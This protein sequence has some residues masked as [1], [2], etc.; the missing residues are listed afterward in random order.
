MEVSMS[1]KVHTLLIGIDTYQAPVPQLQGCKNDIAAIKSFLEHRVSKNALNLRV[2]EDANATYEN[3]VKGFREHLAQA[4][5]G[6]TAL[7]YYSGHG[8]QEMTAPELWHLEPDR[9][10]ETLVCYDSRQPGKN[11]LADKELSSLIAM[12]AANGAHVVVIL[13][14]CHSGSGTRA[15][16]DDGLTVRRAPL[17]PRGPRSLE[18]FIPE[19]RALKTVTIKP[20]VKA[21]DQPVSWLELPQ[22][23]HILLA[24]CRSSQTAKEVKDTSGQRGAFSVALLAAL[25]SSDGGEDLTYRDLLKRAQANVRNV[26]DDQL[27]QLETRN[28]ADI[29]QP[30]LGGAIMDRG[31]YFTLS[32]NQD[33]WFIDGGA[34]HGLKMPARNEAVML[35]VF[36]LSGSAQIWNDLT[37]SLGTATVTDVKPDRSQVKLELK[38]GSLDQ[39]KTYAAVVTSW[40]MP[41]L[42]VRLEGD[43]DGVKFARKELEHAGPE[44][45]ESLYV[46]LVGSTEPTDYRLLAKSGWY[47]ITKPEGE[48]PIVLELEGYSAENAQKV[49]KQLEH[50]ARWRST[51]QLEN[52]SSKI[53]AKDLSLELFLVKEDDTLEPISTDGGVRLEYQQHSDGKWKQPRI[54]AKLTLA[55]NAPRLYCAFLDLTESFGVSAELNPAGGELLNPGDSLEAREG[56]PIF[57]S[58]P[59][60]LWQQGITEYKDVLKVIVS[61]EEFDARLLEQPD[62]EKPVSRSFEFAPKPRS[63]LERLMKRSNTRSL[64]AESEDDEQ[65]G[66]WRTLEVEFTT[67]RPLAAADVPEEANQDVSLGSGVTLHGHSALKAKVRLGSSKQ[68]TRGIEEHLIPPILRE[69]SDETEPFAFNT[70]RGRDPGLSALELHDVKNRD[71]VTPENPLR[72]TI[73]SPLKQDERVLAYAYDGQ[74]YIPMG[75]GHP[76]DGST[77]IVLGHLPD[78]DLPNTITSRSLG[79]EIKVLFQKLTSK[80]FGLEFKG[81]HLRCADVTPI[82]EVTYSSEEA[83]KSRVEAAKNIVLYVHGIIGD[84]LGMAS[85]INSVNASLAKP[86]DLVLTFDYESVNTP[87]QETAQALKAALEQVG[88]QA[89][90]GKTLH[91]IAHSMGGLVSR[92]MIEV[93]GGK[94]IVGKL[95]ML[96]T[97]NAGSPWPNVQAWATTALTLALNGLTTV[98]WPVKVLSWLVGGIEK[99]DE[100]LDQ[101]TPNSKFLQSLEKNPNPGVPYVLI[102]GNTSLPPAVTERLNG[103]PSVLES[104]LGHINPLYLATAPLFG[105]PNDIAASVSSIRHVPFLGDAQ[106]LQAACNHLNY[107]NT[108]DG[109]GALNKALALPQPALPKPTLPKPTLPKPTLP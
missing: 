69:A 99:I 24:A 54:K 34:V 96:G 109:L 11:D 44:G 33:T 52:P 63:V 48:K 83:V 65:N 92:H 86:Y 100:A 25:A 71:Q 68:A 20:D 57:A 73:A 79:G 47:S 78:T 14:C 35:A 70:A 82:G 103:N 8:A 84:T 59:K 53:K 77:E 64:K 46:K 66:D 87:I 39:T 15:I 37:Q 23:R 6:D 43:D 3:I 21:S 36:E 94:D 93:L 58:V 4:K 98:A 12:V 45:K 40:P 72:L 105:E 62:L 97:P 106:K 13:D 27:P 91:I 85:S 49:V 80:V 74:F 90:H 17:D 42:A 102:A 31:A 56:Q 108:K 61:S 30:F 29:D 22:G 104:L 5:D 9:L 51:R 81:Q 26:V 18:S 101:M 2:L 75:F 41:A 28:P 89:G 7:F 10:D 88:L 32:W 67:V 107:F 38:T 55:K 50:I 1:G 95:V 19:V 60:E 16:R 76:K